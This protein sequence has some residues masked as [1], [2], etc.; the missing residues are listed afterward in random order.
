MPISPRQAP[1]HLETEL[2]PQGH[3][4]LIARHH[5]VELHGQKTLFAGQA[6]RV[7][8][9]Q[10]GHTASTGGVADHVAAIAHM[11]ARAGG[12]GLEV[13]GTEQL[14]I[15]FGHQGVQRCFQ[16]QL[17][18]LLLAHG[19]VEGIGFAGSDNGLEGRPEAVEVGGGHGADVDHG[20]SWQGE[21]R[22]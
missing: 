20:G 9:H 13:V 11:I 14:A 7:L 18:R 21:P 12:I 19:R 8:A 15:L 5:R 16:P 2:L 3:R 10:P 17:T 6:L 1:D 4:H 22:V